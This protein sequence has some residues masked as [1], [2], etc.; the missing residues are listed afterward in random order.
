MSKVL[1]LASALPGDDAINGLDIFAK[2][3]AD[4]PEGTTITAIVI[5]D[6]P[7][8]HYSA[9]DGST[10]PT[11]AIRRAEGWLTEETPEAIRKALVARQEKRTGRT[12]LDFG[13]VEVAKNDE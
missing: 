10:V 9:K 7:G 5:F 11:I 3:L 2:A 6:T 13:V 8:F 12:P 4:N 1:K